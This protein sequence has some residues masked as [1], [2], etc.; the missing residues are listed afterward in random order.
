MGPFPPPI[1][2]NGNPLHL[3]LFIGMRSAAPIPSEDGVPERDTEQQ[4]EYL[5]HGR[6]YA[7]CVLFIECHLYFTVKIVQNMCVSIF[8]IVYFRLVKS[9]HKE[10]ISSEQFSAFIPHW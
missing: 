6:Q 7:S 1:R 9:V 10:S 8:S 4:R 5:L 2:T 3:W